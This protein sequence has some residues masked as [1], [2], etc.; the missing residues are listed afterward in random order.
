M[1]GAVS[2]AVALA[3]PLQTADGAPFPHREL[4]LFLTFVV[5]F[6]TLVVQGLTLPALIN[7][8]DRSADPEDA[9]EDRARLTAARAALDRIDELADEQWTRTD[10]AQ[11]MRGLYEYRAQRF[12]A[13]VAGDEVGDYEERSRAYQ[14]MVRAV[15]EAQRRALMTLRREGSL[16]NEAFNRIL[17]D[18]DLEESRLET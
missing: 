13:R 1:R 16:S 18:I 17:R 6:F 11:R 12:E 4:I 14:D 3:L 15:L 10:T 8:L 9:E 2:L 5:I 7:R